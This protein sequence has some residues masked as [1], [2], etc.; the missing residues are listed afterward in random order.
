MSFDFPQIGFSDLECIDPY[1]FRSLRAIMETDADVQDILPGQ[2][3]VY[4]DNSVSPPREVNL[5]PHGHR[6]PVTN[7]NRAEYCELKA[8]F[9]LSKAPEELLDAVCDGFFAVVDIETLRRA[10]FTP[11]ELRLLVCGRTRVNLA[12]LRP[13]T[14][15]ECGG[16]FPRDHLPGHAATACGSVLS[17]PLSNHGRRYTGEFSSSHPVIGWLWEVLLSLTGEQALLFLKFY[18]GADAVPAAG[19]RALRDP[20][21]LVQSMGRGG[22]AVAS[23]PM[24]HTCFCQLDLPMYASREELRTQLL[25]AMELGQGVFAIS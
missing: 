24:A 7:A 5:V 8:R 25:K 19:F 20:P 9:L 15:C 22:G 4:E 3:F 1:E 12:D 21:L 16:A 17:S 2:C 6:I 14:R 18:S 23:L 11:R 13:L 10:Q